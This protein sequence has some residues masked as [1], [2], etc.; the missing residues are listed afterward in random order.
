MFSVQRTCFL[1]MDL[2]FVDSGYCLTFC[3]QRV[4]SVTFFSVLAS[5]TFLTTFEERGCSSCFFLL[6]FFSSEDWFNTSDLFEKVFLVLFATFFP[7]MKICAWSFSRN[8][9]C[10]WAAAFIPLPFDVFLT[11]NV[12]SR[13]SRT[14]PLGKG[15]RRQGKDKASDCNNLNNSIHWSFSCTLQKFRALGIESHSSWNFFVF[16]W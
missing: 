3:H 10:R 6:L 12:C 2:A 4:I 16:L 1:S 13:M 5:L 7:L 8:V 14:M 15:G 9:C 11:R